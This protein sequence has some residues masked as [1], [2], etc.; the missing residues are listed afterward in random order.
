[1]Q[2][3][4][5][6]LLFLGALAG[7][8]LAIAP[9]LK[10]I[11]RPSPRA[12]ASNASAPDGPTA[13]Q[14]LRDDADWIAQ[15]RPTTGGPIDLTMIPSGARLIINFRPAQLWSDS[16]PMAELR[17]S[18]TEDFVAW[19]AAGL[20]S[21]TGREPSQIDEILIVWILGSRGTA[22]QVASVVHL[23][24]E[25]KL[26][27][28]LE[29]FGGEPLDEFAQPK[30]YLHDDRAVMIRDQRT[31]AIAPRDM[32]EDLADFA[33]RSNTDTS[34]GILDI[35]SR[36]DRDRLLTIICEPS[37]LQR[38][39]EHLVPTSTQPL[40]MMVTDWLG[41]HGE[42]VGWSVHVGESFHSELL[43]RGSTTSS[44]LALEG[45]VREEAQAIPRKLVQAVSRM[46]PQRSGF[47]Q[48]IG[49]FPAMM[50]VVRRATLS[51]PE[52]RTVR[53]VTALPPKAA[54]NLALGTILTWD[55]ATRT[56]FSI[57]PQTMA[58]TST[59]KPQSV[60]ERLQLPVEAEF[61]RTPLAEA[62]DYIGREIG[63]PIEIDGDAL[64]DAG[65]T[66]NMAQTFNLG[67][68]PA[69]SALAEIIR[70]YKEPGKELVLSI[71]EPGQTMTLLTRKFAEQKGLAVYAL[72]Q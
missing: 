57:T 54:P 38:H 72:E 64:K 36:T 17:A 68:V 18:L 33:D 49:R 29:E 4:V 6:G 59:T 25:E 65:F 43:V 11:S 45:Q 62:I 19:I 60:V 10:T 51:M 67:R 56:D 47:R 22:P 31:F 5:L 26:S 12:A 35:L 44:P 1:M 52:E 66:K 2:N 55:E 14:R 24:A 39:L 9:Y 34:D 21:L 69:R 61:S 20:K 8:Y 63:V 41:R 15:V 13:A 42:T 23:V 37:D 71:D 48:I 27:D 28:L 32:V 53:F 30:V 70:Q 50:E 16:Q 46:N 7:G 58:A 40:L 3:T